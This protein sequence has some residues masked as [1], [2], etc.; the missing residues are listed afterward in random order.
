MTKSYA[1]IIINIFYHI[2]MSL[3]WSL[4]YTISTVI[5]IAKKFWYVWFIYILIQFAQ[6]YLNVQRFINT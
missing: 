1:N 5:L 4:A 3:V 6:L 2:G